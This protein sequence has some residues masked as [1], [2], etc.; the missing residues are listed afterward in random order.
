TVYGETI[1]D[2]L[3]KT[4]LDNASKLLRTTDMNLIDI[5]LSVGYSDQAG[6]SKAF[7]KMFNL[8]PHEYKLLSD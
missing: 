1:Y 7:K 2:T 4:R 5:A 3:R 8:T 6:F